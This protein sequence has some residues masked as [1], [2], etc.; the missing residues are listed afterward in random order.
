MWLLVWKNPFLR[1]NDYGKSLIFKENFFLKQLFI[2]FYQDKILSDVQ[3]FSRNTL[4]F[5]PLTVTALLH[6]ST[7]PL[8][9]TTLLLASPKPFLTQTDFLSHNNETE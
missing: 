7:K 6:A 4:K 1:N 5:L 3:Q 9:V 2:K 8:A